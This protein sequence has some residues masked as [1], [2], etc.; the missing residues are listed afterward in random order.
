MEVFHSV[1]V[2]VEISAA[3]EDASSVPRLRY[4]KHTTPGTSL[5][6]KWRRDGVQGAGWP[7]FGAAAASICRFVCFW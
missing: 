7:V 5:K 1:R 3:G 2:P 6:K 4:D